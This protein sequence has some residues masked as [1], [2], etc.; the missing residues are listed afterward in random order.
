MQHLRVP[1]DNIMVEAAAQPMAARRP[2]GTA[3][4]E[5]FAKEIST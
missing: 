1:T 5:P 4:K 2:I 3:A